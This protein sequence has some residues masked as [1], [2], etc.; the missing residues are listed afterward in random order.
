MKAWNKHLEDNCTPVFK[1]KKASQ[2]YFAFEYLAEDHISE[3]QKLIPNVLCCMPNWAA[4]RLHKHDASWLMYKSQHGALNKFIPRSF[5]PSLQQISSVP[6][7]QSVIPVDMAM[8]QK[9][10]CINCIIKPY[11][12]EIFFYLKMLI[13]IKC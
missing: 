8:Y 12:A 4:T 10:N 5:S 13:T 1:S 3:A 6:K 11:W 2:I 9:S 7:L